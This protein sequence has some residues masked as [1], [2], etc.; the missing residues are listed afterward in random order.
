MGDHSDVEDCLEYEEYLTKWEIEFLE[1]LSHW[2]GDFTERQDEVL[3]RIMAKIEL[4]LE[5]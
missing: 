1:S 5:T 4:A 2:D 3:E